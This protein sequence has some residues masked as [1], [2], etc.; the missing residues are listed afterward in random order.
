MVLTAVYEQDF[1][2]CS[3]GFRPGPFAHQA[4]QALWERAT[5]TAGG[6]VVELDIRKYFDSIDHGD[7]REVLRRR[8][9]DG[10]LLRLIGKWLRAGVLENGTLSYPRSGSPQGGVISPLLANVFL[11]AVLDAWFEEVVQPRMRG[12]VRLFRY[13][14]D[15]VFVF[16]RKDDAERVMAVL[17]KRFEKYGLTLHPQKTRVIEFVRPDRRS[18]RVGPGAGKRSETFDFLG[19]THYWGRSHGGKLLVRRET[20]KD[21]F[22]RSLKGIARWC[23]WHRHDD[24]RV[25]QKALSEVTRALRVLRHRRPTDVLRPPDERTGFVCTEPSPALGKDLRLAEH[26]LHV[27]G[28]AVRERRSGYP[29]WGTRWVSPHDACCPI[30]AS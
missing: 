18:R 23:R 30:V 3:Y 17:P 2:P 12:Q 13:A 1:L 11:H 29:R 24:L 6:W 16:A 7:L 22:R 19:F 20:A 5:R 14:D 15:A 25:Q 27:F 8:V 28:L 26:A 10:V 4:L 9:L 21:R